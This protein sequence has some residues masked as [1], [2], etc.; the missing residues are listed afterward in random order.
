MRE[1][2]GCRFSEWSAAR[3]QAA[4]ET[5]R[6]RSADDAA[7]DE[8]ERCRC[9]PHDRRLRQSKN[10]DES[11]APCRT[12]PM[13][14]R[15]RHRARN[16]ANQWIDTHCFCCADA[17]DVLQD[18]HADDAGDEK[19]E[20]AT[21]FGEHPGVGSQTDRRKKRQHESGLQRRIE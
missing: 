7:H 18:Q 4:N 2:F 14:A 1:R 15:H 3:L 21:A 6:D 12:G 5:H 10:V 20:C 17:D 16:Q 13:P 9:E 19:Y 8:A 11:L